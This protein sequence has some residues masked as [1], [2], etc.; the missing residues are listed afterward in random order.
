MSEHELMLKTNNELTT[1][2]NDL[3]S[4]IKL[5]TETDKASPKRSEY[6]ED[7]QTVM[8]IIKQRAD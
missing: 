7:L 2:A 4:K 6:F 5:L 3:F 1:I 8:K